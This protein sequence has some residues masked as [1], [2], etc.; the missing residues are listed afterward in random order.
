[1]IKDKLNNW[2]YGVINIHQDRDGITLKNIDSLI[3]E[4]LTSD[5]G[6]ID[7]SMELSG[8][9]YNLNITLTKIEEEP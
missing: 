6:V 9:K 1:M 4:C 7:S 8:E 3:D 5:N 2:I